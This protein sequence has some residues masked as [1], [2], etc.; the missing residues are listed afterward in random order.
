M[1][2]DSKVVKLE[3]GNWGIYNRGGNLHTFIS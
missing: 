1:K 2:R 3:S